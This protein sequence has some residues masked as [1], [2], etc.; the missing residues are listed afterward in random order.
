[1]LINK[2]IKGCIYLITVVLNVLFVESIITHA[3]NPVVNNRNLNQEQSLKLKSNIK[4]YK[5]SYLLREPI[6]IRISV[7]NE[8]EQKKKVNFATGDAL[9]IIDSKGTPYPS[10]I[11]ISRIG[12]TEI[13][14]GDTIE[15]EINL[16]SYLYGVPHSKWKVFW[17][18]PPEKY[19]IS[20]KLQQH[21]ISGEGLTIESPVDTFEIL[22]P[23][24]ED[25][26]A[27]ELLLQSYNLLLEKKDKESIQKLNELLEKYPE[28]GY[29]P[30]VMLMSANTVE[31]LNEVIRKFPK[32]GEA[33]AAVK[34]IAIHFSKKEDK[35]GY[36]KA[37]NDLINKYPETDIANAAYR[38]KTTSDRHFQ[39][40][41]RLRPDNENQQE[42]K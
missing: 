32:S 1:M 20:Y 34:S 18:L 36:V 38:L 16:S 27:L 2:N 29:V 31:K 9:V 33:I 8:A 19:T 42:D 21:D 26:K 3:Q 14:P 11:H 22:E 12:L 17:Y 6:R 39:E 23:Q 41:K 4:L 7:S 37:M 30:Y 40:S 28:S 10:N 35:S 15:E 25:V 24:G 13:N 5:K